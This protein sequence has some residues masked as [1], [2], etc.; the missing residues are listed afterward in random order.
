MSDED[1]LKREINLGE[2]NNSINFA[3]G[4]AG[5]PADFDIF[6]N[7]YVEMEAYAFESSEIGKAPLLKK[8]KGSELELCDYDRLKNFIYSSSLEMF[9]T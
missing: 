4:F 3:F 6:N 5:L 1:L 7:S 2:Y 9:Y 8:I